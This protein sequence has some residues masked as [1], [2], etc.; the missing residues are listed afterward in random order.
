MKVNY[1]ILYPEHQIEGAGI[2][3]KT[4]QGTPAVAFRGHPVPMPLQNAA[5]DLENRGFVVDDQD[6][7]GTPRKQFQLRLFSFRGC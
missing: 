5:G 3:F 7:L 2:S 4:L 6:T 1:T